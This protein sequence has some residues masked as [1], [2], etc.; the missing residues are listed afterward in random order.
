MPFRLLISYLI[1]SCACMHAYAQTPKRYD[2][3]IDEILADPTPVVGLPNAEFIELKNVSDSAF[4]LKNWK[5]INGTTTATIKSN[6]I[7]QPDS[8]V[9]ICATSSANAYSNFGAAI[10]VSNFPSLNNNAD[11]ISLQSPNALIIHT[12]AYDKSWYQNDIKSAGGWSLEMIDTKNPCTGFE[13]WK[14][15][16]NIIGGTPGQKNS[17]DGINKDEQPPILLRTYTIDSVTIVAVFNE[18]LDSNSASTLSNYFIDNGINNPTSAIA[19]SPLF[20]QVILKFSTKLSAN[21]IYHLTSNNISDCVGNVSAS[22]NVKAGLPVLSDTNDIVINE[23]LFNPKTGGYDYAEFYNRSN[24]IIDMQQ[25]YVATRDA[26]GLLKSITQLSAT[27]LLFF[28]GDYYVITE[29]TLWVEQNYLVKNPD[30][31]IE[32]SSLP[33][34]ADDDGIIVLL[35]QNEKLIDELHY[36][37]NWQL[38]IIT[39]ASGIALE[40]IDYNKPT[41]NAGNWASAAST[42]GYGTPTYQNSEFQSNQ[43]AKGEI[44]ITP[45]IFSPDNDGF[46]DYCFINYTIP[47][48]G[49]VANINIYNASGRV[50]RNI[51]ANATLALTGTFRWDGLDDKQQKLP[52]GIYIIVTQIFDLTGKTKQFKNVVTLARRM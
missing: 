5:I 20:T 40:R 30:N 2:V 6:F 49:Y 51:A 44:N 4:N 7:L 52:V 38:A 24:K 19:Q 32:L 22:N 23:I 1:V 25:L 14:A 39:D 42:A 16:T 41:Q 8:F 21:I 12:I 28:P 26:T 34:F 48:A 31:M 13:N 15:S 35:N 45:K 9:I 50:V 29:N 37:S 11:I 36:N 27:P 43:F 47:N 17:I 18:P 10:G 3:V 46:E 33:S